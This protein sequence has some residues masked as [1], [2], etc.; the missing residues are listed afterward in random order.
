MKH[1]IAVSMPSG[2]WC[3]FSSFCPNGEDRT[4]F[5]LVP[6]NDGVIKNVS[7]WDSE[8]EA[9]AYLDAQLDVAPGLRKLGRFV[10]LP[11]DV[12]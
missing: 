4:K 9:Q 2:R 10:I 8:A 1:I 3:A 7:T 11:G 5:A 6:I 12:A